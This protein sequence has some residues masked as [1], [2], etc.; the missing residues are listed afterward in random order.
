MEKRLILF[1]IDGTLLM[2]K[3]F[4]REAKRRAM[5]EHFGETGDI[6]NH[7]FGGK[8][9]W[10]TLIELLEPFG[11]TSEDIG[12]ELPAFEELMAQYMRDISHEYDAEP[13]PHA[14]ELVTNLRER[15]DT[16]LGLVTGNME[17]T[18][19]IK[20]LNFERD[21]KVFYQRNLFQF[22]GFAQNLELNQSGTCL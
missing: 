4:G 20:L 13:I 10:L 6:A 22:S 11:K 3:G 16:L 14:M 8:T 2:T 1:D 5:L 15:E 21:C 19:K 7:V 17:K 18:A 9:D 12:R